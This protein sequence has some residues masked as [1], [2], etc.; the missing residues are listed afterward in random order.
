MLNPHQCTC[1]WTLWF[2]RNY[3]S[4]RSRQGV[5]QKL[6]GFWRRGMCLSCS[7]PKRLRS[8]KPLRSFAKLL[9]INGERTTPI[10]PA[11]QSFI[12]ALTPQPPGCDHP[13]NAWV[14]LNLQMTSV[15]RFAAVM[16]LMGLCGSDLCECGKVQTAYHILHDCTKLKPPCHINEV[17]NP[18]ILEYL[19]QSKFWPTCTPVHVYEGRRRSFGMCLHLELI[20][21]N[22]G[23]INEID[24][25]DIIKW[26]K[27][28]LVDLGANLWA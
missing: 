17:D 5:N 14:Q 19:T 15:G 12:P 26:F 13:R 8:R 22:F 20:G 2:D 28:F 18:A 6:I 10:P 7:A 11:L 23:L 3:L 9:S 1:P 24:R 25:I 21:N 16:K 4:I 27:G